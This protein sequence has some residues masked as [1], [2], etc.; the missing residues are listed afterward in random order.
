MA[1]PT[2]SRQKRRLPFLH[3]NWRDAVTAW[4]AWS[5]ADHGKPRTALPGTRHHED[6]P[7]VRASKRRRVGNGSAVSAASAAG[8]LDP[9][10]GFKECASMWL[11]EYPAARSNS[12]RIHVFNMFHE[13]TPRLRFNTMASVQPSELAKFSIRCKIAIMS[14]KCSI[15]LLLFCDAQLGT[16]QSH[17]SAD[18]PPGLARIFLE[19]FTIP[20]EKI[21]ILHK[22]SRALGLADKYK[23]RIEIES[24]G[25]DAWPPLD[26]LAIL[27]TAD[28]DCNSG[29]NNNSQHHYHHRSQRQHHHHA[30][31]HHAKLASDCV[32]YAESSDFLGQPRMRVPLWL[33]ESPIRDPIRTKFVMDVDVRWSTGFLEPPPRSLLEKG[34]MPTIVAM[35]PDEPIPEPSLGKTGDLLNGSLAKKYFDKA[36]ANGQT[37]GLGRLT[38]GAINGH[39]NGLTNGHSHVN[40]HAA[41]VS[42]N[43]TD[44][45]MEEDDDDEATEGGGHG[46][47][48]S[49]RRRKDHPDYNLRSITNKAHG[50]APRSPRKA[51]HA[52]AT[53]H[54]DSGFHD[55]LR[56]RFRSL[57]TNSGSQVTYILPSEHL[58]VDGFVCCMCLAWNPDMSQLRAHLL[59]HPHYH[60]ECETRPGNNYAVYISHCP[61]QS[62]VAANSR[63][64]IYQL[65][66][67]TKALDLEAFLTGDM[68]WVTS[69]YGPQHNDMGATPMVCELRQQIRQPPPLPPKAT[70]LVVPNI[71]QP[72]YDPLSKALLRPGD[73]IRPVVVDDSWLIHKHR[74]VVQDYSDLSAV[75]KAFIQEWDKFV[76]SRRVSSDAYIPRAMLEFI[77]EKGLWL[78]ADQAR[79]VEFGKHM[80]V[81]VARSLLTTEDVQKITHGLNMARKRAKEHPE[82][83][84]VAEAQA[85]PKMG[86]HKSKGG[87]AKCGLA[88]LGPFMRICANKNCPQRL[89]HAGCLS[90]QAKAA[91]KA[92]VKATEWFCNEC[93]LK[94]PRLGA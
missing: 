43:G 44:S 14:E 26:L 93:A 70:N 15:P 35:H 91:D 84:A 63:P 5:P 9:I 17:R 71:K 92:K 54:H 50:K 81:M 10:P 60:F 13:D 25:N 40:G 76:M 73:K 12:L 21:A 65:G 47:A 78:V 39:A 82:L 52:N 7:Y 31:K 58:T 61:D 49:L 8:T 64:K 36:K 57:D 3:R 62:S 30:A 53:N 29:N 16:L 41:S 68:S 34:V 38:N 85:V 80:A 94:R 46:P 33:R 67:P 6:D 20:L 23:M 45:A 75:E 56:G 32:L 66:R 69:R 37:N 89:Y 72:L 22:D 1:R 55:R 4:Q 18:G 28:A 90:G 51:R 42:V 2:T 77:E 24:A 27:G 88:V 59:C 79:T 11:P 48:R 86:P 19:P 87:C 74:E 83:V